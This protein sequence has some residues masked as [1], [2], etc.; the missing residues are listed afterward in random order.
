M[1]KKSILLIQSRTEF[2]SEITHKPYL[3]LG[4]LS[5]ATFLH[6]YHDVTIFDQRIH[7]DWKSA[8]SKCL[9]K[10]T[11]CIG[12]TCLTGK[13]IRHALEISRY[14]KARTS[15]P[16][17]WGGCHPTLLP[18]QTLANQYIDM[19]LQGE[20][21]FSFYKL[22]EALE[23]NGSL[24]KVAGLWYKNSGSSAR[25]QESSLP[26][27]GLLPIPPYHLVHFPDYLMHRKVG[28]TLPVETSR[29]CPMNCH[30][31]YCS[32]TPG[33][34][35]FEITRVAENIKLLS[36]QYGVESI[37]FIDDNFFVDLER[38][39]LLLER[40]LH[41]GLHLHYE[42]QGVRIDTLEQMDSEYLRFLE[43]AGVWKLDIGVESGSPRILEF[44]NKGITL[45]QVRR[46]NLRLRDSLL[47]PQYN[48]IAGFPT[49]TRED[50]QQTVSMLFEL[51]H[52]NSRTIM[53]W[54]NIYASHPGTTL[55]E[56]ELKNGLNPPASLEEWINVDRQSGNIKKLDKIRK[57]F[58]HSLYFV[59]HFLGKKAGYYFK[60]PV[61]RF[62]FLLYQPIAKFRM[63]R[64]FFRFMIEKKI[65]DLFLN[66][67]Y[68]PT[69]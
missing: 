65:A 4:L 7:K 58:L 13:Q 39:R 16:I 30:F 49:E 54:I 64:F 63:K 34:R 3:P 26:D 47:I 12:L 19:V 21:E 24:N 36:S 37:L 50:I 42:I 11:L 57:T 43:R 18:E 2:Q 46:V 44:L 17:V 38:A 52:G 32:H 29:G 9:G 66:W 6:K 10:N 40:L 31:C 5:L 20:G 53:S 62:L 61:W 60:S 55:Y 1:K 8:L 27:L 14:I 41:E 35:T 48:F 59:S 67:F 23:G 68:R 51:M 56:W 25:G 69:S 33:W 15:A 28:G 22:I 45:D